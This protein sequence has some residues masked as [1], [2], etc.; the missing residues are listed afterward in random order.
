M[1]SLLQRLV[2]GEGEGGG[3]RGGGDGRA[4]GGDGGCLLAHRLEASDAR[5]PG[6]EIAMTA[7]SRCAGGRRAHTRTTCPVSGTRYS[8]PT[9]RLFLTMVPRLRPLLFMRI[10][11]TDTLS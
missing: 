11:C 2:G 8:S 7:D 5:A 6:V 1:H 9:P 10:Q 4:G 3:G